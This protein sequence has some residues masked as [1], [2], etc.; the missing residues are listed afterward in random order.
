MTLHMTLNIYIYIYIPY[1][2]FALPQGEKFPTNIYFWP[3]RNLTVSYLKLILVVRLLVRCVTGFNKDCP[4]QLSAGL[5]Q[6]RNKA[7]C[8]YPHPNGDF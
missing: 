5:W 2:P 6:L 8:A 4:H 1:R 3:I 7:D